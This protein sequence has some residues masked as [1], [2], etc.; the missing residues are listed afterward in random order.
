MASI[1]IK[2]YSMEIHKIFNLPSSLSG[3]YIRSAEI[4]RGRGQQMLNFKPDLKGKINTP[5]CVSEA[6]VENMRFVDK[7]KM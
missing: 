4:G 2:M 1:K 6:F 3:V 7:F 5:Y